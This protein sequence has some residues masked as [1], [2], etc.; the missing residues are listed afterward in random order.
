MQLTYSQNN[1]LPSDFHWRRYLELNDDVAKVFN[2][3][4]MPN[5]IIYEMV[6]NRNASILL[7]MFQMILNGKHI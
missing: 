2:T 7:S 1:K 5:N 4:K 3:K 6:F